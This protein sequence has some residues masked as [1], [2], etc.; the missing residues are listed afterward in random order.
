ML[1]T[2]ARVITLSDRSDRAKITLYRCC[3]MMEMGLELD[4]ASKR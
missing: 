2:T 1:H 3:S 4:F